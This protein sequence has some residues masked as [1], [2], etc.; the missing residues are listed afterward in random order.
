MKS[1][2]ERKKATEEV[3]KAMEEEAMERYGELVLTLKNGLHLLNVRGE[4]EK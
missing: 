3:T 2:E 1:I 4:M